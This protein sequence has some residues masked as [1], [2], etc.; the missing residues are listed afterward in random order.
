MIVCFSSDNHLKISFCG[1]EE[2]FSF[3]GLLGKGEGEGTRSYP[4]IWGGGGG[5]G[6]A[7]ELTFK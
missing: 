3:K 2:G 6:G 7:V 4:P 1:L 5:R